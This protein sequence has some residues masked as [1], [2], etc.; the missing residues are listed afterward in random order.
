MTVSSICSHRVITVDRGITIEV[1]AVVMRDTKVGYLVVMDN[2]T[3]GS[4]V[5]RMRPCRTSPKTRYDSP[6]A[7]SA[8]LTR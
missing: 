7:R 5:K 1:A 8:G 6:P 3:G 2:P 4:E